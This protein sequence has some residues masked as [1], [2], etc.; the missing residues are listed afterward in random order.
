MPGQHGVGPNRAEK[1]L[2]PVHG[3][4]IELGVIKRSKW[5]PRKT[6]KEKQ[7]FFRF[8]QKECKENPENLS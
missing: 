3:Y 5:L 2:Y 6:K 1:D 8:G 7:L 4:I